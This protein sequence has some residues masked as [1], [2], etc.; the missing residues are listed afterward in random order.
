MMNHCSTT[1]VP[2]KFKI[3][4]TLCCVAIGSLAAPSAPTTARD[5]LT[6]TPALAT[7]LEIA[8][9]NRPEIQQALVSAPEIQ[10]TA[11]RFLVENMPASDLQNLSADFLLRHVEL[12]FKARSEAN[13]GRQIPDD[14]FLNEVLPF[15]NVNEH[16]DDVRQQL[17]DQF[18][19]AVSNL[20]SIS[21]A[22]AR[23]NLKVFKQTGVKYST[24]RRRAD[25]GPA[26]T[27]ETGL[28][29]CTGLS[30]LLI[31][32]YRACGIPARFVGTPLWSDNSGNHSWVEVWDDGWH[33]TGAAEPTGDDLNKGWFTDRAS[34]AIAGG[35]HGIFAVSFKKTD[36]RF[37]LVWSRNESA[38][39]AVDVTD[40]YAQNQRS[41][42]LDLFEVQFRALS[43][44]K[45]DRCQANLIVKD[46]AGNV[47]FR[48]QTNDESAD[49][50][51]H[52]AAKLKPGQYTVQ[53]TTA[54]G[55]QEQT[56]EV[57]Q[58]GK[59]VT[60]IAPQ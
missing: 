44:P 50:N 22:A 6:D 59:L 10:Q 36:T 21:L 13:W 42:S 52:L 40:R 12:A 35:K 16:R 5:I 30:I 38:V 19:P 15:A 9:E 46:Q 27:M 26:E 33:F 54:K 48:G 23:L 56:I 17:R 25:Q 41:T 45:A 37:P 57:D 32:T 8:G 7:Q 53:L 18:W 58:D 43:A 2:T 1:N 39:F 29:S 31:D 4:L 11:M 47:V 20:D 55:K 60:L 3:C 14:I 24:K 34:Q 28:A 49:A 51:N